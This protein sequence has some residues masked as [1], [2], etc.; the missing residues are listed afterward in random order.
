MSCAAKRG[1]PP[2]KILV[3][4]LGN[5]DRGDDGVGAIVADRLAGRL[6]PDVAVLAR[7]SDMLSLIEDWAGVDAL[8]CVDAAAPTG[9]PGRI[10]RID[11]AAEDLPRDISFTSS[12]A[13]GFADA[14][15]LARALQLAPQE[16]I[17]YAVEGRCFDGGAKLTPA[18]AGAAGEAAD[19]IVAEVGR[20]RQSSTE[21][22]RRQGVS[23]NFR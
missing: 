20:L 23:L 21:I 10:R 9:T 16:V 7:S 4:G 3:V 13:L 1:V 17:V 19:R 22:T 12:H 2:R 8:I 6:P 15:G 11:L 5:L 14:I 18:V